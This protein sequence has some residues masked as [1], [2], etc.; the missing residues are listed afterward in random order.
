MPERV[1]DLALHCGVPVG[2]LREL[3]GGD[4]KRVLAGVHAERARQAGHPKLVCL[5]DAKPSRPDRGPHAFDRPVVDRE[6][7]IDDRGPGVALPAVRGPLRSGRGLLGAHAEHVEDACGAVGA[8]VAAD[9][10]G[11]SDRIDPVGGQERGEFREVPGADGVGERRVQLR[12]RTG[13]AVGGA[14]PGC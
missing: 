1:P 5:V 11:R 6:P 12:D 3:A 9:R 10:G 14:E 8:F 13:L 4:R 2:E 7:L